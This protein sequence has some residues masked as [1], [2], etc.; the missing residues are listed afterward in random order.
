[1]G[2]EF[3]LKYRADSQKIAAIREKFPG[4]A[5]IEMQTAYYDTPDGALGLRRWTLRRRLENGRSVCTVKIPLPDG[6]RGEWEAECGSILDAVQELCKLGAPKG[7]LALTQSGICEVCAARFT[8]LAATLEV[9][10]CILE[11]ALDQG[12]LLGGGRELPFAEV[13]VELKHGSEIVA[14]AFAENLAKEFNLTAEPAS[15]A[16]RAMALAQK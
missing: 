7:L 6:S 13:E 3:E 5:S 8:R 4:F 1:M 2:R 11:L 15:K 10:G 16:Q 12:S 9:S 14:V